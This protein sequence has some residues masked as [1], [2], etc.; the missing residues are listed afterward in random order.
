MG[1]L[2]MMIM[3]VLPSMRGGVVPV[4][5]SCPSR[6]FA[7]RDSTTTP[8]TNVFGAKKKRHDK[9]STREEYLGQSHDD[10]LGSQIRE[11]EGY[12]GKGGSTFNMHAL[13]VAIQCHCI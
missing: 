1:R 13:G 4:P 2:G 10:H 5:P 12:H 9:G 8:C 11:M 6:F 3:S 7:W